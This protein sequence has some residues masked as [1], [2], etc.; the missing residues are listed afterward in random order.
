MDALYPDQVEESVETT[1]EFL[2]FNEED[3][4]ELDPEFDRNRAEQERAKLLHSYTSDENKIIHSRVAPL[5]AFC[6]ALW[7]MNPARAAK[8]AKR[9]FFPAVDP[10][11]P[12]H[13][14]ELTL[15]GSLQNSML[16]T[17]DEAILV[18]QMSDWKPSHMSRRLLLSEAV[19]IG[20][21]HQKK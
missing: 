14:Q 1:E 18:S 8:Y 19:R 9:N 11:D 13:I 21:K 16:T 2:K 4:D 12:V 20:E 7:A 10:F 3:E 17:R 5:S 15:W 6:L